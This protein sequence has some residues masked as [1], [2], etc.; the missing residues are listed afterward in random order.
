MKSV[1]Y[2]ISNISRSCWCT[3]MRERAL[4]DAAGQGYVGGTL[5]IL[6]L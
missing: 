6:H 4:Y 1:Y 2:A 3:V 5:L